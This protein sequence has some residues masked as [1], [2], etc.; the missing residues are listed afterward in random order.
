MYLLNASKHSLTI[1]RFTVRSIAAYRRHLALRF[2]LKFIL[3]ILV[4]YF[5]FT[6][7]EC[8][9]PSPRCL[10]LRFSAALQSGKT[11]S[12]YSIC[13]DVSPGGS[14]P[15]RYIPPKA[16]FEAFIQELILTHLDTKYPITVT[17]DGTRWL[18][19]A[20][21]IKFFRVNFRNDH[22][23]LCSTTIGAIRTNDSALFPEWRIIARPSLIRL[24][25]RAQE[26][27]HNKKGLI[28][29]FKVRWQQAGGLYFPDSADAD[30][31]FF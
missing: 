25:V 29:N 9:F 18:Y 7:R 24:Y 13:H 8:L 28:E 2:S 30:F 17:A 6:V 3:L 19:E 14:F 12:L 15:K 27:Y 31:L 16:Q 22:G 4:S 20:S 26:M 5:L 21:K 23:V 11:E 1:G 10:A